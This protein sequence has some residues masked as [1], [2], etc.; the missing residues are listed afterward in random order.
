MIL[1]IKGIKRK[2][3]SGKQTLL[4]V[5]FFQEKLIVKQPPD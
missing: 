3:Q 1:N 2:K 4:F 5:G